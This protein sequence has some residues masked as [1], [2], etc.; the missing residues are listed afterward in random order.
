MAASM[1]LRG[2]D[3]AQDIT[4]ETLVAAL[5]ALRVGALREPAKLPGFVLGIARNLINNHF[6]LEAR[7]RET[8]ADVPDP[9]APAGSG[10]TDFDVERRALVRESL[11]CLKPIDRRILLLTLVEGMSPREIAPLVGQTPGQVRTRKTRA[12]RAI[13]AEIERLTRKGR[14]YHLRTSGSKQWGD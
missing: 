3:A 12:V 9:P 13:A 2:S 5:Q 4:Q 6:R 7:S 10:G 1:R 14:Q 11:K 8:S